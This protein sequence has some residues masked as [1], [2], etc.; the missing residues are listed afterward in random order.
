MFHRLIR[1]A[2]TTPCKECHEVC[3]PLWKLRCSFCDQGEG[4]VQS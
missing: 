3:I 1:M 2:T 4:R